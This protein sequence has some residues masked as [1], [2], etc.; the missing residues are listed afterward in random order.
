VRSAS[1]SADRV[2]MDGGRRSAIAAIVCGA[3]F[4]VLAPACRSRGDEIRIGAYLS[5]SGADSTFGTD[6]RDGIELAASEV[7]AAGGVRGKKVRI[8][9]EDDQSKPGE[10][11]NKVRQ[12]IDRDGAVALLG[13]VS[14]SRSIVGGIIAN[15]RHVPM[16]TPSSTAVDVTVGR[17]YVFRTCFTDAQQGDVAARFVHDTRHLDRAAILWVPQ[18]SYSRGLSETFRASFTRL[19]GQI[20]AD[21]AY[22]K[23][24][25]NFTTYLQEIRAASPPAIFIPVYY[26]DVVQIARQAKAIGLSGSLFVGGDAWDSQDLLDGAGAELEGAF[27]TDHYAPDVP[28]ENSKAFLRA[29]RERY[30]H[31]PGSMSAQGYDA[32]KLLFDAIGRASDV[33]PAAVKDALASTRAFQGAT[34]TLTIDAHHNANKPIVIAQIRDKKFSYYTQLLAD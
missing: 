31:E 14:S 17:E 22:Q 27:I 23:G 10:A 11:S 26:N 18:E 15:Q 16:V 20:V 29:F 24:E 28:W 8:L 30:G 7:N 25:T 5:L 4:A 19:G 21:K 13:E 2:R 9:V 34:G 6:T 3:A 33:T 32:A 12:L 1:R